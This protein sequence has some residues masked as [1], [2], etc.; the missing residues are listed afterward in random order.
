MGNADE[1]ID[2]LLRSSTVD[3]VNGGYEFFVAGVII[4]LAIFFG[5]ALEK[6]MSGIIS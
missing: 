1:S 6:M 5:F 3:I 4:T 2:G